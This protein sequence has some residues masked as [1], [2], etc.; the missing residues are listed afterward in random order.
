[1][2]LKWIIGDFRNGAISESNELPVVYNEGDKVEIDVNANESAT[3]TVSKN[4]LPSDWRTYLRPVDRFV[5]LIETDLAW[6]SSVIWAGFINKASARVNETVQIQATGL[7]EYM[8]A[9]IVSNTYNT[10]NANPETSVLF[11]SAHHRGLMGNMILACF[12]S[13]GIPSSSPKPPQVL[14]SVTGSASGSTVSHS[15][16]LS[17][18]ESYGN[19]LDEWRDELSDN[20]QEYRFTPSW[21][22]SSK[23]AIRWIGEVASTSTPHFN[24]DSTLNIVLGDN[25][26]KPIAYGQSASSDNMVS[27]IIGQ[28]K[29][30]AN[31]AGADY[32]TRTTTS[33][34]SILLD[35]SWNP[36]VELTTAQM[37]SNLTARL[38]YNS[39]TFK[40]ADFSRVYETTAELRTIIS[41]LGSMATFSGSGASQYF[42][43]TM[44]IVGVSFN[45]SK[46]TVELQLAPKAARY[47]KLPKDN[48]G[49]KK[50]SET[51]NTGRPKKGVNGLPGSYGDYTNP[52]R[53]QPR[54]GSNG[55]EIGSTPAPTPPPPFT[56]PPNDKD[57]YT[58][59]TNPFVD[60][61]KRWFKT[62]YDI[63]QEEN[64]EDWYEN[65]HPYP[66]A[67]RSRFNYETGEYVGIN[68]DAFQYYS[69]P[70]Y[71]VGDAVFYKD[72]NYGLSVWSMNV[73]NMFDRDQNPYMNT[74][75]SD[76]AGIKANVAD[77]YKYKVGEIPFT[78]YSDLIVPIDDF[79]STI[80]APQ[81]I[82]ANSSS[83]IGGNFD[84]FFFTSEDLQTLY[85]QV[86][87]NVSC[88]LR[89][90]T[91]SSSPFEYKRYINSRTRSKVF[92]GVRN[93]AGIVEVWDDLGEVMSENNNSND[94]KIF[95]SPNIYEIDGK[96]Q[97]F[98]GYLI[99]KAEDM[100]DVGSYYYMAPDSTYQGYLSYIHYMIFYTQNHFTINPEADFV[101][102]PVSYNIPDFPRLITNTDDVAPKTY[103]VPLTTRVDYEKKK[104]II[105]ATQFSGSTTMFFESSFDSKFG[106]TKVMDTNRELSK[107]QSGYKYNTVYA[108]LSQSDETSGSRFTYS[109]K[110]C[111]FYNGNYIWLQ[112]GGYNSNNGSYYDAFDSRFNTGVR[113]KNK[114]LKYYR[115]KEGYKDVVAGEKLY[116]EN[117]NWSN[118]FP[119]GSK[120]GD[121]L[122]MVVML[123]PLGHWFSMYKQCVNVR[124]RN[125]GTQI[126]NFNNQGGFDYYVVGNY[127]YI[128]FDGF[129]WEPGLMPT[130]SNGSTGN[131]FKDDNLK[132]WVGKFKIDDS[133]L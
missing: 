75:N 59:E 10:T 45:P 110:S 29:E 21:S 118:N 123:K 101:N 102:F 63:S 126:D 94:D 98:G 93:S 25:E 71:N 99:P 78:A 105:G 50:K 77:N 49:L 42:G 14:S 112:P 52:I 95:V 97:S 20:G 38:S 39:Q 90:T 107:T 3:I 35:E 47:P 43:L 114:K 54:P 61:D 120:I 8:A 51:K 41:Q 92:K 4:D 13:S 128:V 81:P 122:S 28:S 83:H 132:Y 127:L 119:S 64:L 73:V 57:I 33:S 89:I 53:E 5:A 44:R 74:L 125:W 76:S 82:D 121:A 55:S 18:F 62:G 31:K 91:R 11:Q 60:V 72:K 80:I 2:A 116:S 6:A 79:R 56:M 65:W 66:K 84:F 40:E 85:V 34:T 68:M 129:V 113:S 124:Q 69:T 87:F 37:T 130:D 88:S 36:G 48:R 58:E 96:F 117:Q 1:M 24:E 109:D 26:W 22:S 23:T 30:G 131:S 67:S 32:T 100:K 70:N 104:I 86:V 108:I 16:L 7:R 133:K 12:S 17:D 27:R 15:V 46:K 115:S 106:F 111:I 9:R 103:F 19:M